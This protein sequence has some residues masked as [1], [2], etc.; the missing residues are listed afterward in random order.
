MGLGVLTNIA[1]F[2]S[3]QAFSQTQ[4]ALAT[5]I[6][7]LSS[8]LRINSPADD[9]AGLSISDR[10]TSQINGLNQASR[11]VN[12]GISL[13]QTADGVLASVSSQLQSL[14]TLAVQA[15][16]SIY[17]AADRASLDQ[18]AQS[19]LNT[20]QA[21]VSAANF[22]GMALLNGTFTSKSLQVGSGAHQTVT[23]SFPDS[24]VGVLGSYQITSGSVTGNAFTQSNYVKIN[25]QTQ[26][27]ASQADSSNSG[28]SIGSAYALAVAINAQTDL[29]GVSATASTTLEGAA[30]PTP[31]TVFQDGEIVING[32]SIGTISGASSAI[33]QGYQVQ[34][35]IN[36]QSATTGV[37]ASVNSSTGVITL[38]ASDGRDIILTLSNSAPA[39]TGLASAGTTT[40]HGKL[41]LSSAQSFSL[42]ETGSDVA[43]L[44]QASGA[45]LS[46]LSAISLASASSASN[47]IGVIDS[48]IAQVD[49]TRGNMGAYQ[50]HFQSI[51]NQIYQSSTNASN[52]RSRIRDTDFAAETASLASAQVM[53]SV[54]VAMITQANTLPASIAALLKGLPYS[55]ASNGPRSVG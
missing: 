8:G 2:E 20:I 12:D 33:T 26:I 51:I 28:L 52:S 11:N 22:N 17:S 15:S 43:N 37:S 16:S 46:S 1:S 4:S 18:Q 32:T 10:L 14:R 34:T 39:S 35:A 24:Q 31:N 5:S 30:A 47:A 3:Q 45:S 50:N 21:S 48:A 25:G 55:Y 9:S 49:T 44:S 23:L 6:Q 27:G 40:Q 38:S 19:L 29:S 41:K 13:V 54:D 42:T 7:R 53:Q 36:A